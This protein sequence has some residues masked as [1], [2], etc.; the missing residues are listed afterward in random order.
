MRR[1]V[2]NILEQ[3]INQPLALVVWGVRRRLS[4]ATSVDFTSIEM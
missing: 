1:P 4:P 2:W 3:E